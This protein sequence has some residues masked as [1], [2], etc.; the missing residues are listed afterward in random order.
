[1]KPGG[2]LKMAAGM[3]EPYSQVS[4][5]GQVAFVVGAASGIGRA[6]ALL[7]AVR[8]AHVVCADKDIDGCRQSAT[9]ITGSGG[10]ADSTSLDITDQASVGT[11]VTA[12]LEQHGRLH[13]VLNCA[14]ITGRTGIDSHEVPL[15]DFDHVVAVNLRGAFILSQ[16]VLPHLVSNGYGRL[17]HVASIAGKEGNAG[18]VS[19][20]ATKAAM[21]GMV[22]SMGKEY[23]RTGVTI[24]A[25]AP[26]VIRTSMVDAMPAA[27]V[28]YMTSRIPMGRCG[29]L[30]EVAE[31]T[32]WIL[33]PASSFTTG[34]TFDLSGGRAVY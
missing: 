22:K 19:Y 12:A 5:D 26:A 33:S 29:E 25:L 3:A 8:G 31:M 14:G 9:A 10:S 20:S 34:V 27:Q 7:L 4:L 24:N 17:L 1:M 11:A 2:V 30:T 21:I 23:A 32:A 16:A 13:A 28:E 6:A 15:S 18:M